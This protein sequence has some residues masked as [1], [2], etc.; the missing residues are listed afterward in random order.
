MEQRSK[1]QRNLVRRVEIPDPFPCFVDD[2]QR[3]HPYVPLGM[4][5]GLL[6]ASD[7]CLQLGE[8]SLDDV[9]FQCQPQADRRAI[10][11]QQQ[12]LELAPDP[13]GRQVVERKPA[14]TVPPSP[15]SSRELETGRELHGAKH[16]QAVF[17]EGRVIDR[18]QDARREIG[19]AAEGIFVRRRSADRTR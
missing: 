15:G 13:L 5:L 6:R 18:T 2:Q 17:A 12:L 10:G 3:V 16:A 11:K 19:A 4:P 1:H 7:E 9:Q 14:R 8:Q